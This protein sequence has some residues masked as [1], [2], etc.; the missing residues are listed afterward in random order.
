MNER[1]NQKEKEREREEE[2]GREEI[3]NERVTTKDKRDA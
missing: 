1:I 3:M 2:G